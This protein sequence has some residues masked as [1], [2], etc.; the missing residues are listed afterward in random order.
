MN[1]GFA[2]IKKGLTIYVDLELLSREPP[3]LPANTG[4][5]GE[6][7]PEKFCGFSRPAS[8]AGTP[9]TESIFEGF[10]NQPETLRLPYRKLK[11]LKLL[12]YLGKCRIS[13]HEH[14]T[15]YPADQVEIIR[16]VHQLLPT[17]FRRQQ[18]G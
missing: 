3:K 15:G 6:F 18:R 4:I 14:L 1:Q 13:A 2:Q 9:Q 17:D 8:F 5:T 11:T 12:L 7:L 10:Y 16:T